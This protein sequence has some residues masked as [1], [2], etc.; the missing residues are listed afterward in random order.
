MSAGSKIRRR[1][2]YASVKRRR[3]ALRG[4]ART[5]RATASGSRRSGGAPA[6]ACREL[7][8]D[9]GLST[10][11]SDIAR[12]SVAAVDQSGCPSP[13]RAVPPP[14]PREPR[15]MRSRAS[16][17]PCLARRAPV[18]GA[19]AALGPE[20]VHGGCEERDREVLC[21]RGGRGAAEQE[22][23]R[24]LG[25]G[26]RGDGCD[27]LERNCA[28]NTG[29]VNASVA[30]SARSPPERELLRGRDHE[31]SCLLIRV[32]PPATQRH[33]PGGRRAR[34]PRRRPPAAPRRRRR[35]T[36]QSTRR[37]SRPGR[38]SRAGTRASCARAGRARAAA[39]R[40]GTG[41]FGRYVRART[42]S[43]RPGRGATR[44]CAIGVSWAARASPRCGHRG[45]AAAEG[46]RR[47]FLEIPLTASSGTA[48]DAARCQTLRS[49]ILVRVDRG[50]RC[51]R[52]LPLE[53]RR[54]LVDRR[55]DERMAEAHAVGL[56]GDELRGRR[57]RAPR[58]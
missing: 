34:R 12:A 29:S 20:P 56:D 13:P 37:T 32:P 1:C 14:P 48:S 51:V 42:R 18:R 52:G 2:S 10:V 19:E 57:R 30:I 44:A 38:G 28:A 33:C 31:I 17:R 3:R 47:R 49:G 58:R 35:T 11:R 40:A 50:Q 55:T 16:L 54:L 8:R 45:R 23:D 39:P 9:R 4:R 53:R 22:R 21:P 43:L 25:R 15:A 7:G 27:A 26:S 46:A 24:R 5:A 36:G 6:S 41:R